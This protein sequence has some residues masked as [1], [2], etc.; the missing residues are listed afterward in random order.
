M[1][2][3]PCGYVWKNKYKD[4]PKLRIKDNGSFLHL[5]IRILRP[6]ASSPYWV[7]GIRLVGIA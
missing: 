1:F 4:M 7:G 5:G 2:G 3:V 6:G